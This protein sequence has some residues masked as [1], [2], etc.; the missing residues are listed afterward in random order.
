[1]A[2]FNLLLLKKLSHRHSYLI[3]RNPRTT[4]EFIRAV[5]KGSISV[6]CD[7]VV[8]ALGLLLISIP[9]FL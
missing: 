4:G 3:L 8:A 1:M 6:R 9:A 2:F 7:L 5:G